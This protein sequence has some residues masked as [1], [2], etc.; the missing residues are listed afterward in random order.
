MSYYGPL[1]FVLFNVGYHVEHHD[2]PYVPYSR[3]PDVKR[4]APEYYDHLPQHTSWLK[5]LWDFIF[6][7]EMGPHARGVGYMREKEESK[8]VG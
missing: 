6:D 4:F 5:V 8:K 2:L 3:L 1:N 7:V